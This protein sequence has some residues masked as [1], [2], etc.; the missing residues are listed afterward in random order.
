MSNALKAALAYWALIFGLGFVLGTLRTLW[1]TP[2][3]G[4]PICAVLAELPVMLAASW[5]A[6]GLLIQR[7]T[8][9]TPGHRAFMGLFAFMLLMASEMVLGIVL[10]GDSFTG[11][12][13][14]LLTPAG[15]AGLSGQVLFALFPLF[16]GKIEGHVG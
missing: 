10:L 6:A 11:W 1:L 7:F 3:L 15:L 16:T 13:R 12:L 4:S 5:F 9:R 14:A 8:I 2:L